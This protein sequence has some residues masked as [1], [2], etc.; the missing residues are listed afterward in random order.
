MRR[1]IVVTLIVLVI[2]AIGGVLFV[3]ASTPRY[4]ESI[5][6]ELLI[7]GGAPP[8]KPRPTA[9]EVTAVNTVGRSFDVSV[10][11][12]GKFKLSLPIGKY[13]LIGFSPQFGGGKYKCM[14][15]RTVIIARNRVNRVNVVCVEL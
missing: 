13:T 14:A 5:R 11:S 7:S 4:P 3:R 6:G 2:G 12:N 8:G 10:S 9:G 15:Q 1:W